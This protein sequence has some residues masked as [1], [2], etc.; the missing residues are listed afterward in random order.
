MNLEKIQQAFKHF[1]AERN[2]AQYH[3][4]RSIAISTAVEANE[5]LAEVQWLSDKDSW[6]A[7]TDPALRERFV[8]E[9]ADVTLNVA[10]L[11]DMLEVDLEKE[12]LAKLERIKEKYPASEYKNKNSHRLTKE[13]QDGQNSDQA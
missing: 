3:S 1:V 7:K 2:W 13:A 10:Y 8:A 6:Q 12:A 5:M 11:A 4:P 9:L